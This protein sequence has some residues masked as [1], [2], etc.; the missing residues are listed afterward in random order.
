MNFKNGQ[1]K[2]VLSREAHLVDK[3]RKKPNRCFCNNQ[4]GGY[5][6][7]IEMG[8]MESLLEWPTRF[9]SLTS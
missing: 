6:L 9:Y 1:L 5:F 8:L 7:V 3:T 4:D 2:P